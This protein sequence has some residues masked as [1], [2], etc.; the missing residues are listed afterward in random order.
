MISIDVFSEPPFIPAKTFCNCMCIQEQIKQWVM[1]VHVFLAIHDINT[2]FK[3][4][5]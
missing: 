2:I 1:L 5:R 4:S 3:P